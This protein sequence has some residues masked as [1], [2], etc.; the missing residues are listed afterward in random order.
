MTIEEFVSQ[1]G[2]QHIP[3]LHPEEENGATWFG[4]E[5]KITKSILNIFKTQLNKPWPTYGDVDEETKKMWFKT[6]A[7]DFNWEIG[8]SAKVRRAFDIQANTSYQNHM[9]AWKQKWK[10]GKKMPKCLNPEVWQGFIRYWS[11]DETMS[12]SSQA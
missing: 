2:R 6:F 10:E 1:P 5:G 9:Y 4:L 11:M 3:R 8:H 12:I 7:Q